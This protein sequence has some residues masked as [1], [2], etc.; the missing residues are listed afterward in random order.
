MPKKILV[1][2]CDPLIRQ[3]LSLFLREE[4][5][6][7]NA[8]RDGDEALDLLDKFRFDLVLSDLHS[9]R[10]EGMAVLSHLRS[11]SPDIPTI[12]M[13]GNPYRDFSAIQARGVACV[14]KPISFEDLRSQISE[15]IQR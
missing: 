12:I 4:G 10:F 6:E 2:D 15:L 7:V 11:I 9:P 14:S 3:G 1:I 8:A 13:T 5:Y